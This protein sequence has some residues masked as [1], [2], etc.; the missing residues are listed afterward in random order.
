MPERPASNRYAVYVIPHTHWDRE[1]YATFQQFRIRLVHVMDALLDLLE[2]DPAFTHFNLD[3][4]TVVLQDYLEIRPEKRAMLEKFVRDCRLGVGPW[5]VLPDEFLVSGEALVRNLLL[6][7]RLASDFGHVQKVGYIPDTFGH[8]SQL[9]QIL[10][11]FGIPY[12][13]HFRGLDE[14]DLKSELWWQSPDGSRVLLRHLPTDLGYAN[15]SAL[16]DEIQAA[17]FD[18]QAIA[19]YETRR[20]VSSVLLALNGVDHLPAREDLPAIIEAAN[21]HSRGDYVFRQASLEEY[22]EALVSALGDQPLQTITGELRDVN[23]TPG[24]DNRLLPHILSARIYNKMQNE[25]TQ[26]LLERWAEPWSA[27]LWLQ[28]EEYPK[29][30][31]WKAWE[32]LLQNHPHDS[33]GG[34]SIDPVHAQMETRFSWASE[35]AQEI[36]NERFELL[37]RR[38]DLS[39]LKE[40]EAALIV[41]NNLPWP[42]EETISV[43]I[44]LWEGFLDQVAMQRWTPLTPESDL[45]PATSAPEIYRRR[46]RRQ[47]W[48]DRPILPSA[49]FRGLQIRPLDRSGPLPVQI[50]S[51]GR[52]HILRPLVSG[53]ASERS[54]RRVRAS[55]IAS[56]PALGYQVYAVT[57]TANP[58]KPVTIAHP[59][60]VMENEY[61]RV[62][63]ASNG[64]FLLQDKVSGQA[65]HDL[66]YFEDGGDCGDGYNYSAPLEDRVENT[67]GLEAY[68][69]RLSAGPAVQRYQIDYDWSLPEALDSSGQKRSNTR[70]PCRLS[71]IASLREKSPSLDLEVTFENHVRDHRLRML[72]PSDVST[73]VSHASAQ[74]DVV[75]HAVDAIPV[76]SEAWVEDAPAT[77]PQQEWVDVSDE[78]RGLCVI[79][80]GLPEYEVLNTERREV[81]ITLL[82]A[83]GHLGA[84]TDLRSAAVGAGPHI[85]T[86]E[87]QVQRHLT[88]S[89]ALF[90]HRGTWQSAEV[91]RQALSHNNPPCAITT[92]MVKNQASTA[93]GIWPTRGSF[94]TVEGSNAVLS[95][96]KKA[97]DGEALIL[98]LYNPSD[99]LTQATLLLPFVPKKVELVGLDE[100]PRPTAGAEIAPVLE[101]GGKLKMA[102]AARKIITLRIEPA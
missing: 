4:Q 1:W 19:Q 83:V 65:Y 52:S 39:G 7:H 59:S 79:N 44:D 85:A 34:C 29:T 5:Y 76:P 51:I 18:L 61:L 16:A 57:P 78:Q 22:F 27:L 12:A 55:F 3:A 75:S 74:F 45:T 81:A 43:D 17:A 84:G 67:L 91:W 58:N 10:Q 62:Q 15:A 50:E 46:I 97:E 54:A 24:R 66:G 47:W 42:R 77:F 33:I 35:I 2:R 88:F 101:E 56:L 64:S 72:F 40:D 48:D 96:L 6:G 8:I 37:A 26:T 25:R 92:G 70:M 102:L 32:W 9:P 86:P 20:A 69:S 95:T 80:R 60:N 36:A 30:F 28:G 63:V 21:E 49:G 23:R 31:L 73:N 41:F 68:V 82:R 93:H 100:L 71:V 13:M 98:R 89:L 87:A 94:L 99:T 90:P 14:G 53:L 11:G 38:I